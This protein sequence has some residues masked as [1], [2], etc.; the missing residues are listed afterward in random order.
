V[1]LNVTNFMIA[2][3]AAS[4]SGMMHAPLTGIFL[5]AEITG[6]YTLMVPLMIVSALGYFINKAMLRYSIYT[7]LLAEQGTL[8]SQE[9]K[10]NGVLRSIKLKYILEKDFVVLRPEDTP[11]SRRSDIIHTH[12]NVFP[13]V[14]RSGVLT[15]LLFSDQLLE[16]LVGDDEADR[17]KPV[18]DIAQPPQRV[19]TINTQMFD[20]MQIMD[21][22]DLRILP[23]VDQNNRYLGFVTK[24]SI[25]NKYRNTLKRQGDYLQ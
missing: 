7:E 11:D 21:S 2:G 20:V 15:G 9:N 12:R 19:I 4:V 3:M 6:G 25:F 17:H 24:N 22:Q 16:C 18:K 10:D 1:H 8:L 13:V 14:D 5:A 23:V